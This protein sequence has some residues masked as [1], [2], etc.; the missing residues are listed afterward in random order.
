[1]DDLKGS[2]NSKEPTRQIVNPPLDQFTALGDDACCRILKFLHVQDVCAG[3][4]YVS[5]LV[6]A[7]IDLCPGK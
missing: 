3:V 5:H 2:A 7:S 4:S 6:A 1:M